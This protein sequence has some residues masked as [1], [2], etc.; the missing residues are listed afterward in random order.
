MRLLP[1]VV[2]DLQK[3]HYRFG[4][5]TLRSAGRISAELRC[6][7]AGRAMG[8]VLLAYIKE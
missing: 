4:L 5:P 7:P 1:L 8:P 3:R 6:S 2:I